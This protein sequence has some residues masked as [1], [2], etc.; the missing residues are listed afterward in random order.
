MVKLGRSGR[1]IVAGVLVVGLILV[2]GVV[3]NKRETGDGG[4]RSVTRG[5][6]EMV[7]V[8]NGGPR[9]SIA[10]GRVRPVV[11][12]TEQESFSCSDGRFHLNQ[13]GNKPEFMLIGVAKGGSTSFSNYLPTHPL[14]KDIPTK[15]PN[16]WTWKYMDTTKYQSMFT[17]TQPS[18]GQGIVVAGEYSTSYILHPL[19][20]K[21]IHDELP[22]VK[23]IVLLRNPIDRA[24]SHYT[25]SLR[26]SLEAVSFEKVVA[27]EMMEIDELRMTFRECFNAAG[28]SPK[29]CYPASPMHRHDAKQTPYTIK[30][31]KDLKDYFFTSY[32]FRS[33]Y[34][35]S[36]ERWLS[37]FPRE[38][39]LFLRSEDLFDDPGAVM[40]EARMF[41]GLPE[42]DFMSEAALHVSWGG[43]ASNQYTQPHSYKPMQPATRKMLQ[44][45]FKPYNE[46]LYSL[47]GRDMCWDE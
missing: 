35:D 32:L 27:K 18:L 5:T 9:T 13:A 47:I 12:N 39:I 44:Q 8:R 20:P 24:Y 28:C 43:G 16:F 41:L 29:L 36:V 37:V 30:S 14:V 42:F 23:I 17:N 1:L 40:E 45:F 26:T 2:L 21:R 15:E 19:A 46:R 34:D 11:Q 22:D 10:T 4:D 3:S 31:D 33:I 38:Q 6:A 7:V 25:M